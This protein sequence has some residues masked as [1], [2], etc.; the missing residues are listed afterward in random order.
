VGGSGRRRTEPL[1]YAAVVKL[2]QRHCQHLHIRA[3]WITPH[4]LRHTHATQ[5]WEGGMR[6]L[7]LQKR[8]GHASPDS[9]RLYT[10]VSDATVVAEYQQALGGRENKP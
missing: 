4:A 3:P 6:E 8:L 5:M 2:F 9:T 10:R 1:S 7:S